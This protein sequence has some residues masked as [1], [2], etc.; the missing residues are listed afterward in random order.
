VIAL[1]AARR[2]L[3]AAL[4]MIPMLIDDA[5]LDHASRQ[6]AESP[7]RRRNLNFHIA[8]A[9]ACH[10]LLNAIEPGSYVPPHRHLDPAKDETFVVLR[11]AFGLVT[12][13][14]DG[15]VSD[16]VELRAGGPVL[17]AT[18]PHG[19]FHTLLALEAG[20]VFL[21]AKAGPYLPLTEAER[22]PWAPAEGDPAAPAYLAA[23]ASMFR[24]PPA[25][26]G[27]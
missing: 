22:A 1:P 14:A 18:V 4:P 2:A 5:L 15:A 3:D 25:P 12:F 17:G 13:A 11:G 21:E 10:R 7:R 23:L 27:R 24:A 19:T 20:S 9:D 8:D 6:A 16:T 26:P